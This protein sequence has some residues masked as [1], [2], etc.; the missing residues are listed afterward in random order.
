MYGK[1][2]VEHWGPTRCPACGSSSMVPEIA[3]KLTP[4]EGHNLKRFTVRM[5]AH[6]AGAAGG[7]PVRRGRQGLDDHPLALNS[8]L[9]GTLEEN[10]DADDIRETVS[11]WEF[12]V[13]D[14]VVQRFPKSWVILVDGK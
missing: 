8:R 9:D 6:R 14:L 11:D 10:V 13:G 3:K 5:D 4:Q 1:S 2:E 12:L 7:S